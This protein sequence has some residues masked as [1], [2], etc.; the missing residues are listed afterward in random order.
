[1][2][3]IRPRV[4]ASARGRTPSRSAGTTLH[5][6]RAWPRE[7]GHPTHTCGQDC[8]LGGVGSCHASRRVRAPTT[9]IAWTPSAQPPRRAAPRPDAARLRASRPDRRVLGNP[10][11]RAFAELLIDCEEDRTLRAMLVGRLRDNVDDRFPAQRSRMGAPNIQFPPSA[12]NYVSFV[13][14]ARSAMQSSSQ[15]RT[16]GMST[17]WYPLRYRQLSV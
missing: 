7:A 6:D 1:M 14:Q 4:E 11:T 3:P 9:G 16:I 2:H 15:L 17:R 12:R 13:G 8:P 5:V 10:K